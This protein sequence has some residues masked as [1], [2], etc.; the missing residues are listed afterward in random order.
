[1]RMHM[2]VLCGYYDA[3]VILKV[4][5][6]EEGLKITDYYLVLHFNSLSL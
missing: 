3:A 5:H 1:M 4:V 6:V 2:W